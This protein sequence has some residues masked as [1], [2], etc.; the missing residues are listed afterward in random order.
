MANQL[1]KFASN[2]DEVTKPLSN[3]LSLKNSWTW[4]EPQNQAFMAVKKVL[5]SSPVLAL[6]S[7][8]RSTMVSANASAFGL[9]ASYFRDNCPVHGS[10]LPMCQEHLLLQ[11][12]STHRLRRRL[13][14][15]PVKDSMTIY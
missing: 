7:P 11:S 9:G 12:K 5:S 6:Y 15:G 2:L 14:L 10:Q 13:L 1:G 4:G 3:L 8:E